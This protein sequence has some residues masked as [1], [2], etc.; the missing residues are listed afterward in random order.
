LPGETR[1]LTK[2]VKPLVEGFDCGDFHGPGDWD[3]AASVGGLISTFANDG[4]WV[5]PRI[6]AGRVEPQSTPQTVAFHP[7]SSRRVISQLHR[8]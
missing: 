4:V 3:F 8:G 6:V 1:G 5:A 7:G 2:P